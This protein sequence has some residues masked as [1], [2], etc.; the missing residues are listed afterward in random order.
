MG[1]FEDEEYFWF[2][3]WLEDFYRFKDEI[4]GFYLRLISI[5]KNVR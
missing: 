4:E 5:I 2:V 3:F 1:F